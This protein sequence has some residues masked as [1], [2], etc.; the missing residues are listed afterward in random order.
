MRQ[1]VGHVCLN[2]L[3]AAASLA[4]GVGVAA[5]AVGGLG[6]GGCAGGD[7]SLCFEGEAGLTLTRWKTWCFDL[8]VIEGD[9]WEW[10]RGAGAW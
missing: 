7:V 3:A 4:I 6:D 2:L 5:K 8:G 9:C 10:K 1:A